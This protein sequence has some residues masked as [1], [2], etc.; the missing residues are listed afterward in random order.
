MSSTQYLIIDEA[1][2]C[3]KVHVNAIKDIYIAFAKSK[4][5]FV[6]S[7]GVSYCL[8]VLVLNAI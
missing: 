2:V 1:D 8:I 3:L 6:M 7:C 4:Y 5:V